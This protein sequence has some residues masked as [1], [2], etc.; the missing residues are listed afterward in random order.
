MATKG[1]IA[2]IQKYSLQD[3]PGI[4]STV[5]LKGC[6]LRCG[7]CHNP[8]MISSRQLVWA[9]PRTCVKCGG[10][11]SVCPENA[12]S[13]FGEERTVDR[14]KCIADQGCSKCV[15]VCPTK[16]IDTV[17]KWMTA[18]EVCRT[19]LKYQAFYRRAGGGVCISGGEPTLQPE[20]VLELLERL[21]SEYVNISME[22]CAYSKWDILASYAPYVDLFLIDIKHMDPEKHRLG[23][24]VSNERILE[25]IAKLADMGKKIRIRTPVIPG[26]NDSLENLRKEAAFLM[27][28]RILRVDLLPFHLTGSFKY[29]K[30]NKLYQ[31][32][33]CRE[34]TKAEMLGHLKL[35]QVVGKA[36]GLTGTVGGTDIPEDD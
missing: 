13:G 4:R 26:Y 35:F 30:L 3:G 31:Y 24:G 11:I 32:M 19:L 14:D 25:N 22:T 12:V 20:F 8:E 10:C 21:K 17:G 15:D 28:H 36:V 34:P 6:P 2:D 16:S 18:E 29:D 5:F 33:N 1:L 27:E 7:W 23:T 9:N